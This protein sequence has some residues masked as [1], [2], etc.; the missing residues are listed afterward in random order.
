MVFS[1]RVVEAI[2]RGKDGPDATGVMAAIVSPVGAGPLRVHSPP[3]V[4]RAP[5]E[6]DVAKLRGGLQRGMTVEAGVVRDHQS[7]R[8]ARAVIERATPSAPPVT[9]EDWEHQNLL[10]VGGAVVVAATARLETR[11]AH[12]RTDYPETSPAFQRRIVVVGP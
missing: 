2:E 5:S 12:T 11:G 6:T 1:A 7:L 10:T 9:P 4:E 3:R 8:R